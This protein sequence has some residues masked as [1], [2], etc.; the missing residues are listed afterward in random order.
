MPR[1]PPVRSFRTPFRVSPNRNLSIPRPP[2]N[3]EISSN[4]VFPWVKSG[5]SNLKISFA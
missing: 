3:I 4:T 2:R 1:P 5:S